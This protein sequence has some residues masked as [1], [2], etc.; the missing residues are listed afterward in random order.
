MTVL[1][2]AVVNAATI[3]N[4]SENN[5]SNMQNQCTCVDTYCACA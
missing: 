5:I 3:E 4:Y 2:N 1:V